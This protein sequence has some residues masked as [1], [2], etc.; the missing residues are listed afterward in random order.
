MKLKFSVLMSVYENEN[1]TYLYQCLMSLLNQTLKANEVILVEDG[2]IPQSLRNVIEK[3]RDKLNIKSIYLK[4]NYGLAVALNVGLKHCHYD[5]IARMDSD[6]I[7]LPNRFEQQV[8]SFEEEKD[9]DILGTFA[10]EIDKNSLKGNVRRMPIDH[11]E[12]YSCLYL[13]PF[14][15]SSVMFRKSSISNLGGY[16]ESLRRRQDYDLWFRAGKAGLKF[17]NIPGVL[18]L[19]RFDQFTHLRQSY[20]SLFRQG[21][22]GFRGVWL[23]KQP[24][25]KGLIAFIPFLRGLLPISLQ[26]KAYYYLKKFDPRERSKI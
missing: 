12:I 26:H 13:T 14:I 20:S 10:Q 11:K 18:L 24:L 17:K 1:S 16:N 7:C 9:L 6:D 25:W 21:M 2:V 23:L 15:H 4:K 3:F 19:Y 22:T 5:F 8:K